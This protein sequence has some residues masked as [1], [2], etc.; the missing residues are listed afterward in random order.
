MGQERPT[1][2][3]LKELDKKLQAKEPRLPKSI[4][5]CITR[6]KKSGRWDEAIKLGQFTRDQK[7]TRLD[8]AGEEL[9]KTLVEVI[10]ED[11]PL[12]EASQEV[13]AIWLLGAVGALNVDERKAEMIDVINSVPQNIKPAL[14]ERLPAIRHEVEP[15]LPVAG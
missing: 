1:S 4:R 9:E 2:G 8:Y 3:C 13:K 12:K 5:I 15:F 6:L 14:E 10:C 7:R 11:D